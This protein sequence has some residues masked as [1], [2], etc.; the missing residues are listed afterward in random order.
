MEVNPPWTCDQCGKPIISVEDG[1][2]E[3]LN[4]SSAEQ[5]AGTLHRL[6]LVH[7]RPASPYA[8]RKNACY[9]DEDQWFAAK[10][11]TVADLPLS[12]FV[13]PD[14]LI[15]LLSFLADKRFSEENEVLELIKRLHVPNYEAAR[16][17]FEAAIANGVFEPRSAPSYYDQ[18]E[19]RAVL[20]WAREQEEQA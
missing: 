17:H 5:W 13:G 4:G 6:R 20:N 19:M 18:E 11:Y 3:W 14:G 12:S 8:D 16:H 1:W 2:V 9:H 7:Y 15:T 10:R